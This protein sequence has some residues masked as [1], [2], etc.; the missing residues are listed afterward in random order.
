[1]FITDSKS[2]YSYVP[3][4]LVMLSFTP[5]IW[6]KPILLQPGSMFGIEL[7]VTKL[8][9]HICAVFSTSMGGKMSHDNSLEFPFNVIVYMIKIVYTSA[10]SLMY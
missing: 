3:V 1:M 4:G 10:H 9:R 2:S 8:K 6:R 7:F 5:N